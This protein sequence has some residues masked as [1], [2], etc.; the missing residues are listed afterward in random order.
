MDWIKKCTA[1]TRN[2]I[3]LIER[4]SSMLAQLRTKKKKRGE[5]QPEK[6]IPLKTAKQK[7]RR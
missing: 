5:D 6:H 7:H 3:L 4:A 2:R 1:L